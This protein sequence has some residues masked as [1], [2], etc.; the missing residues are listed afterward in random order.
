VKN[1]YD[2]LSDALDVFSLYSTY[3]DVI[4]VDF[5]APSLGLLSTDMI[6]SF[7]IGARQDP[8]DPLKETDEHFLINGFY[9]DAEVVPVP[10]AVLLGAIGLGFSGWLGRRKFS[11]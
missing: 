9:A 2:Y 1:S 5:G 4:K 10:S 8:A 7:I 6:D 3:S 11:V